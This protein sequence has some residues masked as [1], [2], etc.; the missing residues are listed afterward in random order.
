MKLCIVGPSGA[1]KSTVS[2]KLAK[3]LNVTVYQFDEIYW[4]LSG[5]EFVKNSEEYITASIDRISMSDSWIVEGA[6]DKR[7]YPLLDK[8]TLILKMEVPFRL[9]TLRL[10][11]RFFSSLIAG[12][13]PRETLSNTIHLIHFSY[14]FE[15]RLNRFLAEDAMLSCKV[16]SFHNFSSCINAI[17]MINAS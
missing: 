2:Y 16:V 15:K 8:C 3:E 17:R 11:R 6:Y 1:G 14:V 10:I 4:D 12:K 5:S 7:L 13:R 9:R